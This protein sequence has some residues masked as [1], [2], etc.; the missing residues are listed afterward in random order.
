MLLLCVLERSPGVSIGRSTAVAAP[1]MVMLEI[2]TLTCPHQPHQLQLRYSNTQESSYE[3]G[4]VGPS[5]TVAKDLAF[6]LKAHGALTYPARAEARYSLK[7]QLKNTTVF[8]VH[9][10]QKGQADRVTARTPQVRQ[11]YRWIRRK[12]CDVLDLLSQYR[13][14]TCLVPPP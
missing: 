11:C 5:N 9:M 8:P 12:N 14:G 10:A 7:A 2:T 4:L 1:T 3:Q 6:F 13:C